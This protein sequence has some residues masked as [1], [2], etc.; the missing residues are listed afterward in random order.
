MSDSA[1]IRSH[2]NQAPSLAETGIAL[3][4]VLEHAIQRSTLT[5][6]IEWGKLVASLHGLARQMPPGTLGIDNIITGLQFQNRHTQLLEDTIRALAHY[7][8]MLEEIPFEHT[9][10][11]TTYNADHLLATMHLN[12]LR[13]GFMQM[14]NGKPHLPTP[15]AP[16]VELF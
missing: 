14:I 8:M 5:L 9:L 1:A 10:H 11:E 2:F 7:R 4:K 15:E 16:T 13:H 12:Q 6:A 3:M